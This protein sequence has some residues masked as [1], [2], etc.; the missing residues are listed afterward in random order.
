MLFSVFI[1]PVL[2]IFTGV[3]GFFLLNATISGLIGYIFAKIDASIT[4]SLIGS[5]IISFTSVASLASYKIIMTFL[6]EFSNKFVEYAA[7]NC[8]NPENPFGVIGSIGPAYPTADLIFISSLIAFNIPVFYS[9]KESSKLK[10]EHFFYL[11]LPIAF[12]IVLRILISQ[13]ITIP[14]ATQ[15]VPTAS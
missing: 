9:L 1:A 14:S 7:K 13:A 5:I 3:L 10:K 12:Y 11:I 15:T 8:E 6:V 2:G 4:D